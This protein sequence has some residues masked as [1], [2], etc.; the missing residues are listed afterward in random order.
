MKTF[1]EEHAALIDWCKDRLEE[2]SILYDFEK[3]EDGV[4][5]EIAE[6]EIHMEYREK[7]KEL[8]AK[9]NITD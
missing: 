4:E 8:K 1:K 9:H 3:G 5:R 2:I 7:V 6:R